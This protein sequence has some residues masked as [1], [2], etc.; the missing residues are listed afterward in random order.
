VFKSAH[1]LVQNAKTISKELCLSDIQALMSSAEPLII[2]VRELDEFREGHVPGAINIPRG[3]LEFQIS[4]DVSLQKLN[5][6]TIVYCKTSGRAALAAVTLQAMGF[7][8]VVSLV[9]GFQAWVAAKCPVDKPKDLSF[10]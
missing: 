9:G 7:Q 2:D 3:L 4:N 5:R 8:N 10:E 1:D 6:S